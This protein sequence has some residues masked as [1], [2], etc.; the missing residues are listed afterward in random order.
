MEAAVLA[1]LRR[2]LWLTAAASTATQL[3][4]AVAAAMPDCGRLSLK[5]TLGGVVS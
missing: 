3:N 1:T 2:Q 4:E 5:E